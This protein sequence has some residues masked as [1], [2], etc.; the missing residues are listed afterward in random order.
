[1]DN[2][3]GGRFGD[4]YDWTYTGFLRATNSLLLHNYRDVW[5]MNWQD[6]TYRTGAMN[7]QSNFL[8]AAQSPASQ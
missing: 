8:S 3:V 2:L 4:N 7:V 6:W 1:M 5:G